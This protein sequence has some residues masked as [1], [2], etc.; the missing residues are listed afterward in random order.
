MKKICLILAGMSAQMANAAYCANE[1]KLPNIV[2]ILCD[3]LGI[4]DLGCYGQT[5]IKTPNIDKLADEGILFTD[6]YSGSA[7]SAPSRCCLMTGKH[8]G[9][10]Y[11]RG[12]KSDNGFDLALPAEEVT[13]AQVLKQKGYKTMCVGKWGL[14]GPGTPLQKGFDYFYGYLSQREAHRYY[15]ERLFENDKEVKLGGKAY[16]HFLIMDKGLDF[17]RKNADNPFFAYFSI[18]LPHADLDYPDISEYS[19]E[20]PEKPYGREKVEA[21][22]MQ[23]NPK[24]TYASMV[25]EIDRNVGQIIQLL[26]EEGIWEN[27]IIFFS[28][29]NGVHLTGGHDYKFFN[30]NGPF[31]GH[32]RDLYE[33]G[34]RAPFIV[35]WPMIIKEKRVTDHLSAFW[36]FMPTV[37]EIVGAD[38]KSDGISYL[39]LLKGK[40]KNPQQHDYI[41]HEFYEQGGKQSIRKEGWKLVRLNVFDSRKLKEELYYLPDDKGETNNLIEHRKEKV[42]ELRALMR[43]AHTDSN[44]F[45][46]KEGK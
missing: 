21:F 15:P 18:T 31:R 37:A 34:I 13:V 40:E 43:K 3:D 24:A 29:D 5:K 46:W 39:P 8:T 44:I 19:G 9:H 30:S 45:R 26:K 7:V 42:D 22:K 17:I 38:V 12:N 6:H 11:V 23:L 4:G 41:Y 2:Y 33:G 36:D 10:S 28:S 1:E 16:S 25:S 20:F 14:G 27:T 35:S 32:K